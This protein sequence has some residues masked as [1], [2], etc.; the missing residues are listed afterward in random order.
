MKLL[1]STAVGLA[2][3]GMPLAALAS[4][5]HIDGIATDTNVHY[6]VNPSLLSNSEALLQFSDNP[7]AYDAVRHMLQTNL[8]A[9]HLSPKD[10]ALQFA[11]NLLA[12]YPINDFEIT[13]V[14]TAEPTKIT[15]LYLMQKLHTL[16]IVDALMNI[17]V[18]EA[19]EIIS[20]G[21]SF[22]KGSKSDV[23]GVSFDNAITPLQALESFVHFL[24]T[25]A[26]HADGGLAALSEAALKEAV[27]LESTEVNG[28]VTSSK[29]QVSF[30][31]NPVSI[32]RVYIQQDNGQTL[33]QAWQ[34]ELEL[35][36]NWFSAVVSLDAPGDVLML[37]DWV[38]DSVYRVYPVGVNDPEDGES[39]IRSGSLNKKASPL[40][41]HSQ[42]EKSHFTHTIGNNVYAQENWKGG[43]I[44]EKNHR[45][46]GGEALQFDFPVDFKEHPKNYA[47]ASITNVFYWTNYI[48]DLLYGYGFTEEAGNFQK[49]NFGKGG[50]EQDPV[51]AHS[52]DGFGFNNANFA[53]PPDG[54]SGKMKMYLWNRVIPYRD[55]SLDNGIIVHE[56]LHG[57]S[58]RLTGGPSNVNCLGIGEAGGMGEGWGDFFGTLLR[59][60]PEYHRNMSFT[61]GSYANLKGVRNYPYSTSLTVNPETYKKLKDS[62][63]RGVH[64]IGAVWA[65]M[66]FEIY[67][68]MW[69]ISG[70]NPDWENGNGA[71]NHIITLLIT[72]MILQPCRPTF[73][74]ARTAILSAD[75]SVFGGKYKCAI[76]RGFAKRGLGLNAT[77]IGNEDLTLPEECRA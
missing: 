37:N 42:G 73:V 38:S 61:T 6:V 18:N 32:S 23:Y 30:A 4:R 46:N 29:L 3:L 56:L 13:N 10:I 48:H 31:Q 72:G 55:G 62:T 19:G 22:F 69:D 51:I 1:S 36:D 27:V 9:D 17:H 47:N 53:T 12:T 49:T 74:Q 50:K 26:E 15:N 41:W 34:L 5:M 59:Q 68:N 63:H 21:N 75:T 16:N 28:I 35:E 25:H 2:L 43:P 24:S 14:Y 70:F 11:H 39:A 66:L 20:V 52:Q 44:W 71:N 45:P 65:N 60:R 64:P 40:G 8:Q 33:R 77:P 57:V 67:W 7:T 58:N 54:R 76:W